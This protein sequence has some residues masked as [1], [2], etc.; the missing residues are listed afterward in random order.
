MG[1]LDKLGSVFSSRK[2]DFNLLVVG[3]DNSGKTTIVNCLKPSGAKAATIAPTVG[4]TVDKINAKS[5]NFTT[6]DMSGQSRYRNLWE[7]YYRET[8]ALIFVV[9]SADRMRFVVAME[10]IFSMLE[11]PDVKSKSTPLLVFANKMDAKGA[12]NHHDLTKELQLDSIRGRAWGIYQ[13][14]ALQAEG[15]VEGIAWLVE[16]ISN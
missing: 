9:D 13:T 8:D 2:R 5:L 11:H 4:F 6:Y 7:A 12:V 16:K 10:E 15:I 1:L 3:L 14:N